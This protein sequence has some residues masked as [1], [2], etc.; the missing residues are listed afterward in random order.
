VVATTTSETTEEFSSDSGADSDFTDPCFSDVE[1]DDCIGTGDAWDTL[2]G[3]DA[4]GCSPLST[5]AATHGCCEVVIPADET[6]EL[7]AE[8]DKQ[9][10]EA[11]RGMDIVPTVME[12][13]LAYQAQLEGYVKHVAMKLRDHPTIPANPKNSA[14][15]W[16]DAEN[17]ALFPKKHCAFRG[18]LWAGS[19]EV[20]LD[21]HLEA[22]HKREFQGPESWVHSSTAMKHGKLTHM[23]LYNAAIAVKER[24]GVP[25]VGCSVDRR[26]HEAFAARHSGEKLCAAMCLSCARVLMHDEFDAQRVK[27]EE[28]SQEPDIQW[29]QVF[30]SDRFCGMTSEETA[31]ALGMDTYMDEYGSGENGPDLRKGPAQEEMKDW[32]LSVPFK[33]GNI[34]IICCPEDRKCKTCSHGNKHE[35]VED[36]RQAVCQ[37][38]TLPVC[39]SCWRTLSKSKKRPQL[40]LANDL[41]TGYIPAYIYQQKANLTLTL[42]LNFITL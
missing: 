6:N 24:A 7:E 5:G 35:L 25:T 37:D 18:C 13:S 21:Q 33:A 12:N 14:L 31:M 9:Y 40:A 34:N 15:P 22:E 30:K 2:R 26:A 28:T 10:E 36:G 39:S 3:S 8:L 29:R 11:L 32:V 27:D 42:T 23:G 19:S 20:E 41:W 17:G 16:P 4:E 1:D 38:C